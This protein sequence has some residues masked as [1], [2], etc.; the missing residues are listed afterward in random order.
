MTEH[1]KLAKS[2]GAPE[3]PPSFIMTQTAR[4]IHRSLRMMQRMSGFRIGLICGNAGIGKTTALEAF[5]SEEP[6][7]CMVTAAGGEDDPKSLAEDL[8]G[9]FGVYGWENMSLTARRKALVRTLTQFK[10]L[11]MDEA[12]H[13]KLTALEWLR[14]LCE[15][16]CCD[17]VLAGDAKL[18]MVATCNAQIESRAVL[19]R[20]FSEVFPADVQAIAAAH[21]LDRDGIR[22]DLEGVAFKR[23]GIRHVRN[24]IELA[25]AFA[26]G[27]LVTRDHIFSAISQLGLKEGK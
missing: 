23:G 3:A 11:I 4:E 8:C 13:Y 9:R 12:Q 21:S 19:P 20:L 1:L 27:G 26:N 16:A 24:V 6:L 7:A 18:Y 14:S 17:L 22:R 2:D 10:I 15:E 25:T 5:L